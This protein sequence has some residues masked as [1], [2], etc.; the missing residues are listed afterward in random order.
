MARGIKVEMALVEAVSVRA[1]YRAE[2]STRAAVQLA[3][4]I[5]LACGRPAA[6][7][8]ENRP[9]AQ[10]DGGDVNRTPLGMFRQARSGSAVA[11]LADVMCRHL[12]LRQSTSCAGQRR[13][14]G[15]VQPA[16]Q[17]LSGSAVHQRALAQRNT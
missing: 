14:G 5:T 11:C 2:R 7:N 8:A 13:L 9:I 1:Q 16:F 15:L 12:Q 10:S 17:G 6:L 3:H 4:D